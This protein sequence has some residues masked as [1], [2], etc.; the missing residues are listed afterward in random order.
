MSSSPSDVIYDP[1]KF[2]SL[3]QGDDEVYVSY[4]LVLITG[5]PH[6]GKS[7]T[8]KKFMEKHFSE[9]EKTRKN[10]GL[11]FYELAV[12]ERDKTI[13]Y[14]LVTSED[15][16]LHALQSAMKQIGY[17]KKL[18][19]T[20]SGDGNQAKMFD[21]DDFNSHFWNIFEQL[22]REQEQ[23]TWDKYIFGVALINIWDIGYSR[24]VHH[25]ISSLQHLLQNRYSWLFFDLERDSKD[26]FK[27]PEVQNKE[28]LMKWQSRLHYL[29][30]AAKSN[31]LK[32]NF[33]SLFATHDGKLTDSEQKEKIS[34]IK[35]K[36]EIAATQIGVTECVDLNN[37]VSIDLSSSTDQCTASM[38]DL[39][40]KAFEGRMKY[41]LSF[42]FLRGFFYKNDTMLYAKKSEI[43][44]FAD[45]LKMSNKKYEDFCKFFTSFG[46]I[47][48]VSLIDPESE[49]IIMKPSL[50]LEE[51]DK[52][53]HTTVPELADTGI[54][55]LSTAEKIFDSA[56]NAK[57]YMDILVSLSQAVRLTQEQVELTSSLIGRTVL[58]LP[59]IRTTPPIDDSTELRKS[60]LRLILAP[61]AFPD[62]L[63][64][65]FVTELLKLSQNLTVCIQEN[66]PTNMTVMKFKHTCTPIKFEVVH[67]G[68][69][70]E[71]RFTA[72]NEELFDQIV[73]CCHKV[74]GYD[75]YQKTKYNFAIMCSKDPIRKREYHHLPDSFLCER[76]QTDRR[77]EDPIYK[78]WNKAVTVSIACAY[79]IL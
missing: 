44:K 20:N 3:L 53:F 47:I 55:T 29:I 14:Q 76:C 31:E 69:T 50:F 67:F 22:Q 15:C 54:L 34:S 45:K 21:D 52:I 59:D 25:F 38:N 61:N 68:H 63:Q 72:A 10:H 75:Y 70:L 23:T 62:H 66:V 18:Q 65:S 7:E 11:S 13:K 5:L 8:I 77:L 32:K 33:C 35:P 42:I 24:T 9:G 78:M 28:N 26:S 56:N 2:L 39:V 60:V 19:Y 16:Y 43:K 12:A 48:D 79:K 30:R 40:A 4:F 58:Y 27:P 51:I 64:V 74:M 49:Y 46:S 1:A 57:A 36:L 17:G 41:P 37:I 71:F 73:K 6:S